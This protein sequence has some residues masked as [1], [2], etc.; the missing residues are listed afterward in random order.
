MTFSACVPLTIIAISLLARLPHIWLLVSVS[1]PHCLITYHCLNM[2]NHFYSKQNDTDTVSWVDSVIGINVLIKGISLFKKIIYL[3]VLK[4]IYFY[5]QTIHY[6]C[7]YSI[8]QCQLINT[9]Y[10][11]NCPVI[12]SSI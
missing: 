6:L 4:I 2:A 1:D 5:F 8:V 3:K 10:F 9:L 7:H 11:P 12:S